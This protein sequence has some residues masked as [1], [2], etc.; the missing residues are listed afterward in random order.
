M[1]HRP[2]RPLALLAGSFFY[3]WTR[4]EFELSRWRGRIVMTCLAA[5]GIGLAV[6]VYFVGQRFL[7]GERWLWTVG[8]TL[9]IGAAI[10]LVCIEFQRRTAAAAVFCHDRYGV[11][12]DGV[13]IWGNTR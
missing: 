4:G 7:P 13:W 3:Q 12:R 2:I 6:A 9:P 11:L 5:V 8:L 10:C 1:S